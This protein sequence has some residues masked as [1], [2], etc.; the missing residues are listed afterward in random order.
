MT[1]KAAL[2]VIGLAG[3]AQAMATVTLY[4]GEGF[5][6][7]TFT[8]SGTV[9]DLQPTGFNDHA[10]SVIVDSGRWEACEDSN[11]RGRCVTLE[12]GTYPTLAQLGMLDRIS[13]IRPI[14]VVGYASPPAVA[15]TTMHEVNVASVHAV[16]GPP[17]QRCWVEREQVV[18]E[19]GGPNVPGAIIG[20]VLGGV[21][22][23]Q[24]GG[25]RGRDVAT[26]GG[27]VAGAAI[28][29]NVGRGGDAVYDR[30][31]QRCTSVPSSFQP[32]YWDVTYYF[33][34]YEHH[35]QLSAPPGPT[36]WVDDNGVPRA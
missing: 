1:L 9:Y 26:A 16:G 24:I 17:D 19:R 4:D 13:S 30:D 8:A 33:N 18:G 29:A 23:H 28:G 22:G 15:G 32:S 27:A 10:E 2:V 7:R 31:V 3:A 5:R 6:G 35:A 25:G 34:G 21:L 20:G 36:L 11:F 14:T 12:P